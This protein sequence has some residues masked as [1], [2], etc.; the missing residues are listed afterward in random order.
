MLRAALSGRTVTYTEEEH[1]GPGFTLTVPF[2]TNGTTEPVIQFTGN[3]PSIYP[4]L[5]WY[6]A[7]GLT[8]AGQHEPPF[9]A[10]SDPQG[11]VS[12]P[13]SGI[14]EW[15]VKLVGGA[16]VVTVPPDVLAVSGPG[17][18]GC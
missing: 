12:V 16:P 11:A 15:D 7:A 1:I 18:A 3:Q 2:C 17:A 14:T 4:P 6:V 5:F 9:D 10:Q 13:F 8:A